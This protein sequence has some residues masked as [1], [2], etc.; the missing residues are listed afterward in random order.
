ICKKRFIPLPLCGFNSQVQVIIHEMAHLCSWGSGSGTDDYIR[1]IVYNN[2]SCM[3]LGSIDPYH[4]VRNAQ[5]LACYA[6]QLV[7]FS[8]GVDAALTLPDPSNDEGPG[9]YYITL[10]WIYA[11]FTDFDVETPQFD[12]GYPKPLDAA[13]GADGIPW[14]TLPVGF[15]LGF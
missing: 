8:Y 15:R 5:N 9:V 6:A 12:P 10:C 3:E 2:L 14:N 4:A 13:Q 1:D 7:P 11:R